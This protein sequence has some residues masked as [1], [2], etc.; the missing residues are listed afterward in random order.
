MELL[1]SHISTAKP[2]K[3]INQ[4]MKVYGMFGYKSMELTHTIRSYLDSETKKTAI[5]NQERK[6]E[7]GND[8]NYKMEIA[9]DHISN[10]QPV[11]LEWSYQEH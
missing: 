1:L 8:R 6:Q 10:L 2:S 4:E 7:R 9:L 11:R 5:K 3:L